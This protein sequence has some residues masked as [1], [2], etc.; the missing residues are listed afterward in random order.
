MERAFLIFLF[1]LLFPSPDSLASEKKRPEESNTVTFY[2][3]NDVINNRD[4]QYTSGVKLSWV[5]KDL[6]NYRENEGVP[7]WSYPVTDRLPF[8]KKPGYQRNISFSIGQNIYTP[9]DTNRADLIK[10]DRPYAGVS[11]MAIGFLSKNKKRMDTFEIDAG[12]LGPHSYASKFHIF[13]HKRIGAKE[14]KGWDNQ[15]KDELF[16][17]LSYERKWRAFE[18]D[19]GSGFGYDL[20]P[21]AGFSAGNFLTAAAMGGQLRFGLNLPDD[22]GTLLIRPGSN[23]NAP[24]DD[25]DPRFSPAPNPFGVHMFLGVDAFAVA[26]D[27]V[28]DGN[29]FTESHSVGKETVVCRFIGGIGILFHHLKITYANVRETK[30]FKTQKEYQRYGSFTVSY[31][32]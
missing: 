19:L 16:L 31:S 21:Y 18:S 20:I 4:G 29:T 8:N 27:I 6:S 1:I 10:D 3:E 28:L 32:F 5:S 24:V 9:D 2:M 30:K 14:A 15:L 23:T 12:I 25:K 26:R 11:Y 17:N 7:E 13:F 22:F